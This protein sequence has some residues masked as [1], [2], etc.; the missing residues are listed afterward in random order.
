MKDFLFWY[1]CNIT[2]FCYGSS[3]P[4]ENYTFSSF[5]PGLNK[6]IYL[7]CN[8]V[9]I[10]GTMACYTYSQLKINCLSEYFYIFHEIRNALA[11]HYLQMISVQVFLVIAITYHLAFQCSN[12]VVD[13][14][15]NEVHIFCIVT[16][17]TYLFL[18][19]IE[20]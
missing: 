6:F 2:F 16:H 4:G 1:N 5:R 15:S 11:N 12:K 17:N 3:V 9:N 20:Q 10:C 19:K 18:Y 13:L 7:V 14:V 8:E